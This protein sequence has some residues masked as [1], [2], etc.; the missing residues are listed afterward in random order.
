MPVLLPSIFM[1]EDFDSRE[2][3]MIQRK[4]NKMKVSMPIHQ[5]PGWR[6]SRRLIGDSSMV[7]PSL[8]QRVL[9]PVSKIKSS[10]VG[11]LAPMP[12]IECNT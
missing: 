1:L 12:V 6:G 2:W 10:V 7:S 5:Q 3:I 11:Q 9:D 8:S 4:K